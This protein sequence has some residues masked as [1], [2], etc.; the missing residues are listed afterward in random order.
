[1]VSLEDHL[2]LLGMLLLVLLLLL[3]VV[4]GI[5]LDHVGHVGLLLVLL[6]FRVGRRLEGAHLFVKHLN[7]YLN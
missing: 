2:D 6:D 3:F 1:M 7:F 5:I 4:T